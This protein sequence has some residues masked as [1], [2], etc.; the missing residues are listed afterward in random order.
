MK[1]S[2]TPW[3]ASVT[4]SRSGH[5][6]ALMR[7]RNS[8]SSA[9][10]TFTRNGRIAALSLPV[11]SPS[12]AMALDLSEH[13]VRERESIRAQFESRLLRPLSPRPS[14][15]VTLGRWRRHAA[16]LERQCQEVYRSSAA[17]LLHLGDRARKDSVER[18]RPFAHSVRAALEI[19][20]FHHMA[21]EMAETMIRDMADLRHSGD[22][23]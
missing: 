4:V 1:A 10:G 20:F 15:V 19:F 16:L 9:S 7:L 13:R 22:E 11:C 18:G 2:C 21:R 17:S 6:V 12:S 3:V 5:F 8:V 14:P 23:A